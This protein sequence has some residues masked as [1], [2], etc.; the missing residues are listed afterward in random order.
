MPLPGDVIVYPAH[1]AGS[2]CGKN[3]GP[4]TFSTIANEKETNYALRVTDEAEFVKAVID[5]LGD[6]PQYFPINARINKEG[7]ESIDEVLENGLKPLSV[8]E[9][10]IHIS[11]LDS[12]LLDTRPYAEFIDGFIPSSVNISLDGRFAEWAGSLLSFDKPI[13]LVTE[14]GKEKES[15]VR[16]ARVGFASIAGYLDG[17]Y[18]AW[19]KSGELSDLIINIE[20]DELAMDMKFDD[21][22]ILIDV[23]RE[24]EYADGHV[25]EAVNI[26]LND[27]SD[28]GSMANIEETD[29]V[30]IHCASGYRSVIAA[31]LLKRQGFHNVRNVTGGFEKIREQK[32]IEI[33]K[34]KSVLN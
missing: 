17:G 6:I 28:P 19:K 24:T 7:Y 23:R 25:A 9:L 26:P 2:S 20:A 11:N 27:L 8:E 18:D 16:L 1:G 22:L 30:Y 5:G 4:E 31:S 33:E 12:T 21:K 3:L 15:V 13:I 34:E 32:G 14:P 10:K 29:N